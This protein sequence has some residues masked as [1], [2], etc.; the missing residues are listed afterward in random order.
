MRTILKLGKSKLVTSGSYEKPFSNIYLKTPKRNIFPHFYRVWKY[1]SKWKCSWQ[2]LSTPKWMQK[3]L[4]YYFCWEEW[5]AFYD[6][7]WDETENGLPIF[8]N[9]K[10]P[11]LI[12]L[13]WDKMKQERKM[14]KCKHPNM[15]HE[16]HIGPES[17][18]EYFFCPDCGFSDDI[19]YY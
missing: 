6:G 19:T 7:D 18:G 17:G 1:D 8:L 3:A 14:R 15:Y 9:T 12:R 16:E 11:S 2:I 10:R 13:T 4:A 5:D